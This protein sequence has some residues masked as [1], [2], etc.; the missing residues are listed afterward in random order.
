MAQ[1]SEHAAARLAHPPSTRGYYYQLLA[2]FGWSSLAAL[3]LLRQPTLVLAGGADAAV[4]V[5][6]ARMLAAL[7]PRA[8]LHVFPG[9]G[10]LVLFQRPGEVSEIVTGFL[11]EDRH[12]T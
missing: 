7:I 4:P 10:H 11:G 8:R 3:P 12:A 6:N 1:A 9:A 2:P 5:V